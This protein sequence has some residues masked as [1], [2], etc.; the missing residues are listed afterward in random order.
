MY[1]KIFSYLKPYK[2]ETFLAC[3][4]VVLETLL[5]I[6]IPFLMNYILQNNGGINYGEDNIIT[7]VNYKVVYA[8]G[9]AMIVSAILAFILGVLGSKYTAI[10]GRGLGANLRKEQFKKIQNFSFNNLDHFRNDSL[11]TRLTNDITI[12]QDWFCQSLRATLRSPTLLLFSLILAFIVSPYLGII[13]LVAVPFLSLLIILILKYVKPK[14]I[15]LQKTVDDLNRV[16]DESIIAIKTVKSYVKEDYEMEKFQNVNSDLI[17]TSSSAFSAI[18][19]NLPAIQFVMYA[20]IIALLTF[21]ASFFEKG[22]IK[23]VSEIS[24]FLSYILQLLAVL[25]MMSNVFILTNRANASIIRVIDVLETQSEII[26]GNDDKKI[27]S[28][29]ININKVNFKYNK[30]SKNYVLENINMNI[31]NGDFIGIFGQT[32]SGKTTLINL[33]ERF[34]DVTDGEIIIDNLNIKNYKLYELHNK[35]A[36]CFQNPILFSGTILDNLKWGNKDA[37]IEEIKKVCKIAC[38]DDFINNQLPQGYNTMISQ[39]GTNLSGGQRQRICIARA[40]LKN[41]K[42]LILD[43]SFS[44]LDHLTEEALKSNLNELKSITKI[45]ISQK[46]SAIKDAND[47]YVL[48][49][50]K[51]S[52][53]GSH[54]E[55]LKQDEIYSNTYN[56]QNEG[57]LG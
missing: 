49:N 3:L 16:T 40:L 17:K 37:S 34:Y 30:K 33:I 11:I 9:I 19:M 31:H 13:F 21:G 45:I 36:V 54:N 50:G 32:G 39:G 55:L 52:H 25:I 26:D 38:C 7:N 27:N 46:I 15:S 20:T 4:F 22:L 18:S 43:D 10:A 44:A 12:I 56:I 8:I 24:T 29:N 48:V 41:P 23:D 6:V 53:H 5:E 28:G 47:I 14:F 1:K 42:I 35:I 2:K 51:I 57:N